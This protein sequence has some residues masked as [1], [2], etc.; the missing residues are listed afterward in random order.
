ME[1]LDGLQSWLDHSECCRM[2][3]ALANREAAMQGPKEPNERMKQMLEAIPVHIPGQIGVGSCP[4]WLRTACTYRD[5]FTETVFCFESPGPVG[6][7]QYMAFVY[8][9]QHP[10]YCMFLALGRLP[11]TPP[12]AG[13]SD[14]QVAQWAMG[15]WEFC[16][17]T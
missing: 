17:K 14:A 12:P 5:A 3:V 16:V 15:E 7:M 6:G 8:A 11:P 9:C 10:F 2:P 13:S 1:D 4:E